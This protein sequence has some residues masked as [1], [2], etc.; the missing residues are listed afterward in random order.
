MRYLALYLAMGIPCLAG[1]WEATAGAGF[2][3]YH[4]VTF[5]SPA[6][7]AEAGIGP[8]Y[9]LN[10]FV[11]RKL[12]PK[13]MVEGGWLFQDG[14][15]ELKSG[16]AKTAFDANT[17]AAYADVVW[18]FRPEESKFRPFIEGGS[19][20]KFYR[21]IEQPGPRPLAEF[22]SFHDGTDV[23]PLILLGAGVEWSMKPHLALRLDLREM[24][25][26]FPSSVIAPAPGVTFSGWL[27][28]FVPTVGFTFK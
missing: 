4:Y 12:G 7:S 9:A 15:F 26:P 24:T 11:S 20:A 3:I 18:K 8:R 14:D 22:G 19:G 16:S 28:D 23:R 2:G 6:G 17:H 13:L 1:D 25:T 27:W 10:A 21:G 5:N